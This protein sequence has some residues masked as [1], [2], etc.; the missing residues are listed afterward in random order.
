MNDPKF[1]FYFKAKTRVRV[2]ETTHAQL[3]CK[4]NAFSSSN[5]KEIE[6]IILF[7]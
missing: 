4:R 5:A 7:G 1:I 2:T 3:F 6:R